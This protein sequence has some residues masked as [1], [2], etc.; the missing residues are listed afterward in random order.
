MEK[1]THWI[2]LLRNRLKNTGD[3]E[4][5][6]A[7]L[8]L[9]IAGILLLYFC[10]PWSSDEHWADIFN[11][12][13]NIIIITAT[14]FAFIIF[15]AI[16]NKP[17]PSPARRV[18]GIVLDMVSLSIIMYWT[19][20]D[21]VPLFVFYLWV[22]LG[23][24]FRYGIRYLYISFGVSLIGFSSAIFWSSYWQQ[25]QSF[26]I[27]LL[28]I[29]M[30]LP[31]YAGVL[32]K[33]LHAAI[34]SAKQANE[35]K[36]RFLANMSHELRTPLNGVIG[37][38]DLLRETKLSFEQRELVSTLHSSAN[39]LLELI[40]N[41]LD[42]AKIEAGKI[43]IESKPL[44]LHALVNSV[45]FMLSPMGNSKGLT[46]SCTIDPDTPFSLEGDH[47]HLRQVLINLV[48]NAIKFTDEGSV[49]LH[50][51]RKGGPE[52]KPR[53]RFDI[54]DTGIGMSPESLDTIFD[55][56]TQAAKKSTRTFA[57]TGLGTT[58]SK[59]LVELMG[60]KIGVE[61]ELDKGSLFWVEIPFKSIP[62]SDSVI[63][64]NRL[65]LLAA[66][67][68]A[69][70][71]RPAL[72]GW[73]IEF[74]WVRSSPRALSLLIQAAEQGNHYH[75]V[76]VDQATMT[77]IN[78]E[79]FAQM[80]KSENL[81]ENLSLILV[82]S[83][84][85][86]IDMNSINHYY[87]STIVEP[88]DRRSLFN[89]IHAAQS[90]KVTDSNVVTMAEHYSRQAGA[91]ILNI[92]VAE[93]NVINQ[94]VIQGILRHAGHS[95]RIVETGEMALDVLSTDLDKIDM[96]ILDKNMPERSGIEVVKSLRFMDT[97][98]SMPVIM[99]TADA[100]PEAREECINAGANAYLTK[101]INV[102]ELLEKIAVLSRN[103][104]RESAS[105]N[106]HKAAA[107]NLLGN[108]YPDS[109]RFNETILHELSLLGDEPNFIKGLV[110]NFIGDGTRHIERINDAAS[111]DY[112]EFR[113]ALHALKGS[114]VELGANKLVD[115]CLKCEALKP[116]DIGTDRIQSM[117]SE[118]TRVFNLT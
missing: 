107:G 15:A 113:E 43:S 13:P 117:V 93:D 52:T 77:D 111:H 101:P 14:S 63:S 88:E 23:N 9:A 29:L 35:A 84:D 42:I 67:D 51:Y 3:S 110:E 40:E 64:S 100:T 69:A 21:H 104:H 97:T 62:H 56:F 49:N 94:K 81:L 83:S 82:N 6:Q 112:L 31:V 44:D 118:I 39:S 11:S 96:L 59:E 70:A 50:V 27:S 41:V 37:M 2:S 91:N 78:P 54:V 99:L 98:L 108:D 102:K 92:L 86:M 38:G 34:D 68:T 30:I 33:K 55:D 36:S 19:G 72:K 32:L 105:N 116:Y 89:A 45:I 73:D 16:I 5:E 28:I 18:A 4:P 66:E 12:L 22:T 71:I 48:N 10:V 90:V 65:V 60:G 17:Q 24:G 115:I 109:P 79:Q 8:R 26:A 20:G 80:V 7:L 25:N 57:G 53:I 76:I 106:R 75:S 114:S 1:K 61:S 103:I 85:T 95:V 58:I 47:Q 46:V 74:D 87:I